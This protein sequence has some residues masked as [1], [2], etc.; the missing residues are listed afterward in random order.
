MSAAEETQVCRLLRERGEEME[1]DP[2]TVYTWAVYD[3]N[4]VAKKKM[5]AQGK[6]LKGF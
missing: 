4:V 6:Q 1:N 3:K 5:L 2:D